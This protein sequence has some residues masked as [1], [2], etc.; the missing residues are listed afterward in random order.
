MASNYSFVNDLSEILL[1]SLSLESYEAFMPIRISLFPFA[2]FQTYTQRLMS[3]S[4]TIPVNNLSYAYDPN[5]DT[6]VFF[7]FYMFSLPLHAFFKQ[8]P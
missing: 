3:T 4:M 8:T 5:H 2:L 7:F 1:C 6:I